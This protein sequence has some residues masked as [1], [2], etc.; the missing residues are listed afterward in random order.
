LNFGVLFRKEIVENF[1]TYK[2]LIVAAL[3][4]FFGLATPLLL[5]FLPNLL[6]ASGQKVP[7]EIPTFTAVDVVDSYVSTLSQ[8]GLLIAVL[9]AMGA[10]ALERERRTAVM[11][12]CKPAGFGAFITAKLAALAVTFALGLILGAA[13]C[14]L[15]TVVLLGNLSAYSFFLLN[16]LAGLYLLVCLSITLMY[17]AIFRNQLAV[18]GLALATLIALAL[19]TNIPQ[20][21]SWLPSALLNWGKSLVAGTGSGAWPAL[22][23]SIGIIVVTTLIG[24]QVLKKREL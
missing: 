14:Y 8:I 3:L 19:A 15:Y 7:I 22:A 10:I 4:L 13:G 2:M 23:V 24:W 1:K 18:G 6:E 16:V 5:K 17:S 9:V 21:N 12:L 11:T 20:L